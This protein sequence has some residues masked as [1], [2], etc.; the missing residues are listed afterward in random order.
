MV[1]HSQISKSKQFNFVILLQENHIQASIL[2][3]R[4]GNFFSFR[5]FIFFFFSFVLCSPGFFFWNLALVKFDL[6]TGDDEG[7]EVI[8]GSKMAGLGNCI[9]DKQYQFGWCC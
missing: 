4:N 1:S 7:S 6:G 9:D 8:A 5:Y 3:T 2:Y